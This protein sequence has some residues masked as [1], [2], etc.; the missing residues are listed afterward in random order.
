[1]TRTVWSLWKG[2]LLTSVRSSS[3][4]PFWCWR[5]HRLNTAAH[6]AHPSLWS[7]DTHSLSIT[8]LQFSK[9]LMHAWLCASLRSVRSVII[10]DM[11][12]GDMVEDNQNLQMLVVYKEDCKYIS[13]KVIRWWDFPLPVEILKSVIQTAGW[14]FQCLEESWLTLLEIQL[15]LNASNVDFAL[16]EGLIIELSWK[17][18]RLHFK[19]QQNHY[20]L[21]FLRWQSLSLERRSKSKDL[22]GMFQVHKLKELWFSPHFNYITVNYILLYFT[23]NW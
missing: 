23:I 12:T 16:N 20:H 22:K 18:S 19:N 5:T 10:R 13:N 17:A 7:S 4:L 2:P 8:T 9:L 6:A 3:D 15:R 1:M 11:T 21:F 14:I